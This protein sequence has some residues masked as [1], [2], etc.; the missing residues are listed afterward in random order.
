M[1]LCFVLCIKIHGSRFCF[2][3][4]QH[5]CIICLTRIRCSAAREY[6]CMSKWRSNS[7]NT[8]SQSIKYRTVTVKYLIVKVIGFSTAVVFLCIKI[9]GSR[10]CLG[11]NISMR[12]VFWSLAGIYVATR[13]RC[14]GAREYVWVN[15]DPFQNIYIA[16]YSYCTVTFTYQIPLIQSNISNKSKAR[17]IKFQ[18]KIHTVKK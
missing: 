12:C 11:V 10:F 9:H 2:G 14:S 6:V 15:D 8:L 13:I 3:R 17:I 4:C 7:W 18:S 16:K 1:Q 5:T